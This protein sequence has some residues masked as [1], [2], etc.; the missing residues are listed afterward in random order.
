[1]L[2]FTKVIKWLRILL[3]LMVKIMLF[4]LIDICVNKKNYF[5]IKNFFLGS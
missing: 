1:M 2:E 4:N 5:Y 3:K